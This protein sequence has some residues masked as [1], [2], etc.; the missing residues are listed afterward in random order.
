[1][2]DVRMHFF[3]VNTL[4]IITILAGKKIIFIVNPEVLFAIDRSEGF[5]IINC[6]CADQE[7]NQKNQINY[8]TILAVYHSGYIRSLLSGRFRPGNV[9]F[10]IQTEEL[11]DE[12]KILYRQ[13]EVL[14]DEQ[15]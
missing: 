2:T 8:N 9:N 4:R 13:S 14:S 5:R 6:L 12:K 11:Y 3:N 10:L 7:R 1:M 15:G